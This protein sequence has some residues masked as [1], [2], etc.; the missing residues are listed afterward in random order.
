[1]KYNSDIDIYC[2]SFNTG[3]ELTIEFKPLYLIDKLFS[4]E[5]IREFDPKYEY[6]GVFIKYLSFTLQFLNIEL[7]Y[8]IEWY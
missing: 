4:F 1:M 7:D 3:D 8:F 5:F 6:D 2:I